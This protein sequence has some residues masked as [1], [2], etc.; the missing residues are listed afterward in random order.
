MLEGTSFRCLCMVFLF[1]S[2]CPAGAQQPAPDAFPPSPRQGPG[3]TTPVLYSEGR[4]SY[5]SSDDLA[6]P[7]RVAFAAPAKPGTECHKWHSEIPGIPGVPMP[8]GILVLV[9][10]LT[11]YGVARILRGGWARLSS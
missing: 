5:G 10:A 4:F 3:S 9:P 8:S 11:G 1:S 7:G 6:A 2:A